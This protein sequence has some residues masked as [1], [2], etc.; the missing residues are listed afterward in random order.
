M[1]AQCPCIHEHS[2][3][4]LTPAAATTCHRLHL[5]AC[6]SDWLPTRSEHCLE[7]AGRK[8][9]PCCGHAV[10]A[11]RS[12]WGRWQRATTAAGHEHHGGS[13][14]RTCLNLSWKESNC[15]SARQCLLG[16]CT[17]AATTLQAA[18]FASRSS[19]AHGRRIWPAPTK[20][21]PMSQG[22]QLSGKTQPGNP[23]PPYSHRAA[24]D[25][26]RIGGEGSREFHG[27]LACASKP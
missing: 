16:A 4:R 14:D 17:M 9:H 15:T 24:P 1:I 3:R 20:F 12:S 7:H 18:A 11:D 10:R 21:I 8:S 22:G 27:I 26:N 13:L 5:L 6:P 25:C 23:A 19:L 2:R